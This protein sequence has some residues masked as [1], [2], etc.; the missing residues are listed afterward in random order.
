MWYFD[1]LR[2]FRSGGGDGLSLM[3]TIRR[4]QSLKGQ[5]GKQSSLWDVTTFFCPFEAFDV[6]EP[7]EYKKRNRPILIYLPGKAACP[8]SNH[9]YHDPASPCSQ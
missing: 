7:E 1:Y 3:S 8:D 5:S 9:G 4:S 2:G 6:Q